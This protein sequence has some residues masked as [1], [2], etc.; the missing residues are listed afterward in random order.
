LAWKV[1][2]PN[3]LM[4]NEEIVRLLEAEGCEMIRLPAFEPGGSNEWTGEEIERY[5]LDADAFVGTFALKPISRKV[6]EAATKLRVGASPIIGTET[7]DVE[8]ATELGIAIGYGAAP[9]NMLGVAEAVVMLT[10]A[11]IK[12][13]PGKWSAVREG[14]WRTDQPGHMVM[15]RT[16]GLIGLGN[17]GRGTAKRFQGWDCNLLAADPYVKPEAAAELGVKLVDLDTLLHES[18]VV[19]IMVTL[20]D[21]T[22]HMI[23]ERELSLMQPHAY[24]INTARGPL[25]DEA[26]LIKALDEGRIAGAAIDA[27]EQE[28]TRPDNPLRTHPKVIATGHNVGH[29][30]EVYAALP[31]LAAENILKGLRGEPPTCFRNPEALDRWRERMAHFGVQVNG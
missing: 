5:W 28:P 30:E 14:G 23:G 24:L 17:I 31:G 20:T 22:R 13:L 27:W 8:A 15:N 4:R 16:V 2:V 29:S 6:L 9:E 1:V 26:A 25:V 10:A 3:T 18:D 7:M 19:S 12:N 11:L 21:S